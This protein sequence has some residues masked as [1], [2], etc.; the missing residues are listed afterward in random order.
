MSF[1]DRHAI[2]DLGV[3]VG[4]R[5][6]HYPRVLESSEPLMDWFE[7]ISENFLVAGGRPLDNLARLADKY[8]VVPHGVSLAIGSVEPLDAAY[9]AKLK[10]L[11]AR[12]DPPWVSDHLCWARAPGVHIHDL[13]PLP[14]TREAI[15]HVVERVKRVQGTLE[16]PFA[17]ENVSSYMTYRESTMSE[18]DFLAEVA[19]R[20]DCGL[21]L[22]CNNVYVSSRNH[23]FDPVT[24]IDAVPADRVVQMHLAG[25]TDK[26]KYV[27]DTHSDHVKDEVWDLYRR[28]VA[29]CGAVST[30]V[31]WDD[32]IPEWDVLSAEAAKARTMRA[33]LLAAPRRPSPV[34]T[35][36]AG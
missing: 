35:A 7:V 32:D 10:D 22:D 4:F 30:L 8:R 19:E 17:L 15:E 28:A 9:L 29:R 31:E 21:L 6:P 20:A 25:H 14:Y 34:A 13:L 12:L 5:I 24:Y 33:E 16:R 11:F 3:G 36:E 27:L 26:G 1:R 23:G 18:W 2:P